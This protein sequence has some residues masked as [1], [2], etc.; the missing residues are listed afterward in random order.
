[1]LQALLETYLR[2]SGFRSYIDQ[3]VEY[4]GHPSLGHGRSFITCV[5]WVL[6]CERNHRNHRD[7]RAENEAYLRD[8]LH[9]S[10]FALLDDDAVLADVVAAVGR[11]RVL[12][13]AGGTT[14]VMDL[15]HDGRHVRW[16][17]PVSEGQS[18]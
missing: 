10:F 7:L 5:E 8:G 15:P 18:E 17:F 13:A 2:V 6:G 11:D 12:K 16:L 14:N 1:M 4:W 9:D 3:G